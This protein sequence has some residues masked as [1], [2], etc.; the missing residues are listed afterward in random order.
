MIHDSRLED[1]YSSRLM[2]E[3]LALAA[4][5]TLLMEDAK[6][7]LAHERDDERVIRNHKTLPLEA[8]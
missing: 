7:L 5:G 2:D 3:L 6:A 4:D 1:L 8:A